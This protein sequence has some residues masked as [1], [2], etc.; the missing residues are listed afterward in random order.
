MPY[1][2]YYGQSSAS[3]VRGDCGAAK[4]A[5]CSHSVSC[6]VLSDCQNAY[7]PW[8]IR[9]RATAAKLPFYA[10]LGERGR[11]GRREQEEGSVAPIRLSAKLRGRGL[12]S[13]QERQSETLWAWEK[14]QLA[15]RRKTHRRGDF[16]C[17]CRG[18]MLAS[19][20]PGGGGRGRTGNRKDAGETCRRD[21]R[22]QEKMQAGLGR[23]PHTC[24]RRAVWTR[25]LSKWYWCK[26]R[27]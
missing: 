6:T 23:H 26:C 4:V 15:A 2:T 20:S 10:H 17:L 18:A 22:A 24:R 9:P 16:T 21:E 27:V 1:Q 11:G 3:E 25:R 12:P 14:E 7:L 8:I 13:G 19:I 5:L